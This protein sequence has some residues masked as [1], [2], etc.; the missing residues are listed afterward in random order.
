MTFCFIGTE[1]NIPYLETEHRDFDF[2][3]QHGAILGLKDAGLLTESQYRLAEKLL[4][5]EYRELEPLA[6]VGKTYD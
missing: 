5:K 1:G 4:Y 6:R 3:V 2:L